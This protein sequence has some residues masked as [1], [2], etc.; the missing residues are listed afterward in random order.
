[1]SQNEELYIKN[2]EFCIK[3]EEFCIQSDESCRCMERERAEPDILGS[4]GSDLDLGQAE[5]LRGRVR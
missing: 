3:N 4:V 2:E 1:M 5:L